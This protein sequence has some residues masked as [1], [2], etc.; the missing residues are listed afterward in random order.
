MPDLRPV[1]VCGTGRSGTSVVARMLGW[2]RS[3]SA[4]PFELRFHVA[5]PGLLDVAEGSAPAEPFVA[6]VWRRWYRGE[7]LSPSGEVKRTRGL[8]FYFDK[9]ELGD[10]LDDLITST[11]HDP[12]AAARRLL[13][14]VLGRAADHGTG[15]VVVEHSPANGRVADRLAR[16]L[17]EAQ[18]I[19]V[20]RDGRDAAAS[21]ATRRFG[22]DD[23]LDALWLWADRHRE[24]T[25]RLGAL[26]HDQVVTVDLFDLVC[27]DADDTLDRLL[28]FLEVEDDP[29]V[30]SYL[31]EAMSPEFAGAGRWRRLPAGLRDQ[32]D[33]AYQAIAE[34]CAS[35]GIA[36]PK[37]TS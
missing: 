23:P 5:S 13:R 9:A 29:Y 2:H 14:A 36:M 7:M 33:S 24:T 8:G 27:D 31:H 37:P 4:I 17:P 22:P 30:R 32:L 11:E 3:V 15:H 19:A 1:F 34:W 6:K 28:G 10:L 25:V 18:F 12:P 26:R 20:V 16:L 35:D 21:I